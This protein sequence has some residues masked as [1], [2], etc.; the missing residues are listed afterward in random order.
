M[1]LG[2]LLELTGGFSFSGLIGQGAPP[3]KEAGA[4]ADCYILIN[5]SSIELTAVEAYF[6]DVAKGG[7]EGWA[8]GRGGP[9][10]S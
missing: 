2:H 5:A 6:K 1:S 4:A 10:S 8:V 3:S 7:S 9:A